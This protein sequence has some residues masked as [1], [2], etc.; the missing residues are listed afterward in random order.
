MSVAQCAGTISGKQVGAT[1][2]KRFCKCHPDLKMKMTT[3]LEKARAK[4][5][6]QHAVNEFFNILT[7]MITEYNILPENL[8]NMDEKGLQLGI[9]A[10]I[11]AIIN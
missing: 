3:R 6:N 7:E 8:Y 9:G 10:K 5:L 1:W 2:P 4:A 11:T